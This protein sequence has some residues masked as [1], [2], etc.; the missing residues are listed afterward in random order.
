M[1]YLSKIKELGSLLTEENNQFVIGAQV[2]N[3]NS[4]SW[5]IFDLNTDNLEK[6]ANLPPAPP[7]N[8]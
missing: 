3:V 5:P 6:N 4:I 1:I 8:P 7:K 2:N